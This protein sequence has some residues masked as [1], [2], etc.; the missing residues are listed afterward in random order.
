[1]EQPFLKAVSIV[2]D[3]TAFKKEFPESCGFLV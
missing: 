3:G 1:M 2:N